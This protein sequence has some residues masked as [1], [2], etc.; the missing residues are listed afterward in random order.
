MVQAKR[1]TGDAAACGDIHTHVTVVRSGYPSTRDLIM[2]S[3][4]ANRIPKQHIAVIQ[5]NKELAGYYS[6]K[7]TRKFLS[8]PHGQLVKI[9]R[10]MI[11]IK[12]EKNRTERT[13]KVIALLEKLKGNHLILERKTAAPGFYFDPI[14]GTFMK[15]W[16]RKKDR[17]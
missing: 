14:L 6:L 3:V 10:E 7:L 4:L 16:R 2:F 17:E 5:Q 13:T 15:D 9:D 1:K 8:L 12:S 11:R